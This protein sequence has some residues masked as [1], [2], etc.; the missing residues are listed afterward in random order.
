MKT[1]TKVVSICAV[2]T[3]FAGYNVLAQQDQKVD[4]DVSDYYENFVTTQLDAG[5]DLSEEFVVPYQHLKA[6][7]Y[8]QAED[9]LN[10][11]ITGMV[12]LLSMYKDGLEQVPLT[13]EARERVYTKIDAQITRL[14]EVLKE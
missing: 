10:N 14:E 8:E 3:A 9:S 12:E 13:A 4:P 11:S 6:E 7:E 1:I 5:I 2:I